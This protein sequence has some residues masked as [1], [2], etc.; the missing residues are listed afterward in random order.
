[1]LENEKIKSKRRDEIIEATRCTRE[2]NAHT[3]LGSRCDRCVVWW[4]ASSA[5]RKELPPA[6]ARTLFTCAWRC[7]RACPRR[8]SAQCECF[9]RE[10]VRRRRHRT[11]GGMRHFY[12][13][14][15]ALPTLLRTLALARAQFVK[16]REF[17]KIQ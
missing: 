8:P 9:G 5:R 16:T 10:R 2:K 12:Q 14:A 11:G 3:G 1:M 6:P 7:V 13:R 15:C 17:P 4:R